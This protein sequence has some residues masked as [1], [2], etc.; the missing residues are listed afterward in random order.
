MISE[1]SLNIKFHQ[2]SVGD[3]LFRADGRTDGRTDGRD[4]A[5]SIFF[6]RNFAKAP[7]RL[8]VI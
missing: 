2:T 7:N 5:N 4:E 8:N 3:Y 6:S 1:K